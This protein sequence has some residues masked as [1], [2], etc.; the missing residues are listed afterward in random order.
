MKPATRSLFVSSAAFCAA[1]FFSS[2]SAPAASNVLEALEQPPS[3]PC[4]WGGFYIG[5]N[6]GGN[7]NHFD[8]SK[9]KTDV[10]LAQQF[11][12]MFEGDEE[13]GGDGEGEGE[14]GAF[15]TFHIPGHNETDLQTV[16]GGQTGFK[17]QFGN[18]VFGIEGMFQGNGSTAKSKHDEFQENE[19]FL[20]TLQQFTIAETEFRNERTIE[21][22]WNGSIGGNIGFCWNRLLFYI[23][24]G[25]AFTD[26]HFS[27]VDIADT[28]FFGFGGGEGVTAP[29]GDAPRV[30]RV[31]GP[32]QGEFF[33][34]EIVSKKEHTS[35]DVLTGY[36]AGGGTMYQ[37]TNLVSVGVEYRHIDWGETGEHLTGGTG[38][39]FSGNGNVGLNGD[40]VLF[41]VNIMVGGLFP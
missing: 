2:S 30:R 38:P 1:I 19:L 4:Q 34:G 16:G 7:W 28:S 29:T 8:T 15:T 39:V 24:G 17:F 27:S 37:L 32:S 10:D 3:N 14:L 33:L 6:V 41:K 40:Q 22:T 5:F 31:S 23:A 13:G 26:V 18:F 35:G 21:T 25:A 11:Y 9:Q 20:I 36:Y 12:E